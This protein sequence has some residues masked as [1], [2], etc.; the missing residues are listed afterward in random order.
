MSFLRLRLKMSSIVNHA[1]HGKSREST[2]QNVKTEGSSTRIFSR[3]IVLHTLCDPSLRD[4][5]IDKNIID[6]LLNKN[7]YFDAPRNSLV[8]RLIDD[9]LGRVET[10]DYVCFPFFSSHFSLPV[11]AGEQIWVFFEHSGATVER[12]YWMS[13]IS[14]PIFVEDANFSHLERKV[15]RT[16]FK[17]DENDEQYNDGSGNYDTPRKLTFQNGNPDLPEL[18]SLGGNNEKYNEIIKTSKEFD[19]NVFEPIPRVTK[20]PGDLVLQGSNNSS[21]V[22]G[23]NIGWDLKNRPSV[24]TKQSAASSQKI[25]A[26]SVDIVVGRGRIFKSNKDESTKKRNESPDKSTKPLI[27]E[28]QFGF[29]TDKNVVT[30]QNESDSKKKGNLRTNPQ[31][32]DADFLLDAS[33]ILLSE[34]MSVDTLFVT[35]LEGIHKRFDKPVEDLSGPTIVLKTDHIRIVAKKTNTQKTKQAEPQEVQDFS[36]NGSI[37]IIKEGNPKEDLATLSL[38]EDGTVHIAGSKIFFGRNP[39]DGGEG[40]GPG[41]G[42][43]QPYVKYSDLN[44]LLTGILTDIKSFATSLQTNFNA[45]TTPGFGAPNPSLI[46]SAIG[47]C[48]KLMT[49]MDSRIKQIP[50]IKSK[51][52]FGE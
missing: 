45:N 35:G 20:R 1:L 3:A 41:E 6:N 47:E 23:S 17:T 37:R 15:Q 8:C 48:Q 11:K 18:S 2:I 26:G 5:D 40:G 31:E 13:R 36:E 24:D 51:R 32:G 14:G 27:V 19:Q 21:I 28:N 25:N 38:E 30:Q 49:D 33:R 7:D 22:L 43:S 42:G 52:I 46:S 29:E 16:D 44:D 39:D 4:T 12:P 50:K 34:D 9:G 10:S